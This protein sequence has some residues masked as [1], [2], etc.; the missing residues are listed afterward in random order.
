MDILL[1]MYIGIVVLS[2]LSIL[3]MY[4][5]KKEIYNSISIAIATIIILGMAYIYFTAAPSNYIGTKILS[6]VLAILPLIPIVLFF[7]KKIKMK[8]LKLS[9]SIILGLSVASPLYTTIY[10]IID[11]LGWLIKYGGVQ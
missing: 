8:G 10:F 7:A 5:P 4:I 1:Y 9:I 11:Y 6:V 3:G 2:I